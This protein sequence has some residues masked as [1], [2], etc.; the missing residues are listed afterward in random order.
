[1]G[2]ASKV[3]IVPIVTDNNYT[4]IMDDNIKLRDSQET[5]K[6][7]K[8]TKDK[9]KKLCEETGYKQITVIEY[10]LNGKISLDKLNNQ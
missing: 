5:I 9:I 7:S 8:I 10:L 6:I 3:T 1:V 4:N 2:R